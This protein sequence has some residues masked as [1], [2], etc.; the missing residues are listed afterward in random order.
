MAIAIEPVVVKTA[1]RVVTL[2]PIPAVLGKRPNMF[3]EQCHYCGF[4]P[5]EM[6]AHP[7]QCPKCHGFAWDRFARPQSLLLAAARG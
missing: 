6:L 2:D 3:V 7:D 4:E 1:A 5:D